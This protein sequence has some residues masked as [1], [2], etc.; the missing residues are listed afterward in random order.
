VRTN[1]TPKVKPTPVALGALDFELYMTEASDRAAKLLGKITKLNTRNARLLTKRGPKVEAA[2]KKN[3]RERRRVVAQTARSNQRYA[4]RV[5]RIEAKYR[6]EIEAFIANSRGVVENA[7]GDLSGMAATTAE[8]R[9]S[10][11]ESRDA[12]TGYRDAV[13]AQRAM[14]LSQALNGA[15]EASA[16]VVERLIEDD[17][18]MI[19]YCD[20]VA[21]YVAGRTGTVTNDA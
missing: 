7:S 16:A 2:A 4:L 6:A 20:W 9:A 13:L 10:T 14:N 21:Q 1:A 17:G 12:F 19:E 11:A 8:L 3:T 5:G 15:A 18:K